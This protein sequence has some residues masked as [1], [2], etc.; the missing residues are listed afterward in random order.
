MRNLLKVQIEVGQ[1]FR[2]T[3]KLPTVRESA[4]GR[5]PHSTS[6]RWSDSALSVEHSFLGIVQSVL[7]NIKHTNTVWLS[8]N[9]DYHPP[10]LVVWYHVVLF[11]SDKVVVPTQAGRYVAECHC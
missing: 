11:C 3:Q 7:C 10:F 2:E 8:I 4:V 6:C 1:V 9:K 5:S